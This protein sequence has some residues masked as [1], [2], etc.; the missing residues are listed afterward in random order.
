MGLLKVQ[1]DSEDAIPE[2]YEKLYKE[3]DGKWK[4]SEV[5]GIKTD[6]DV[7]TVK[8]HLATER[9][10]HKK[11]QRKLGVIRDAAGLDENATDEDIDKFS[12]DVEDWK[13][14]FDEANDPEKKK[15]GGIDEEE[16]ADLKRLRRAEKLWEREK[17]K[18]GEERDGLAGENSSLKK[19]KAMAIIHGAIDAACVELEVKDLSLIHI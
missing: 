12:S 10:E 13:E 14:A 1:Y 11:T 5:D 18:I 16:R 7:N 9:E 19:D 3:V 15:A 2:G 8:R 6:D 17:K 4:L